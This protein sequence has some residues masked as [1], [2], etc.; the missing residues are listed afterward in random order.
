MSEVMEGKLI[1]TR[2]VIRAVTI[3]KFTIRF[4]SR[5]LTHGSIH[6]TILLNLKSILFKQ[7]LNTNYLNV[8]FNN[9]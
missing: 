1:S 5:F 9:K 3:H 8:T 6:P 4:V 2:V 7:H